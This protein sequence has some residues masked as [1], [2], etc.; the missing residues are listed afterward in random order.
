[1]SC[2][3]SAPSCR[4]TMTSGAGWSSLR[5]SCCHGLGWSSYMTESKCCSKVMTYYM[6]DGEWAMSSSKESTMGT[7]QPSCNDRDPYFRDV[8]SPSCCRRDSCCS[9]LSRWDDVRQCFRRRD[10]GD[11]ERR[12]NSDA[13][14]RPWEDGT[15]DAKGG[16]S[17]RGNNRDSSRDPMTSPRRGRSPMTSSSLVPSTRDYTPMRNSRTDSTMC[18]GSMASRRSQGC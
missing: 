1:M 15:K 2:L 8:C 14:C 12:A 3:T 11:A 13:S 18:C 4:S 5:W 9:Y 6:T 17:S 16:D 10:S 7:S